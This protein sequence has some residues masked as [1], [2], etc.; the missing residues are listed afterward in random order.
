MTQ[1]MV[2]GAGAPL[3]RGPKHKQTAIEPSAVVHALHARMREVG[4]SQR[5]LSQESGVAES[6]L[7]AIFRGWS[8]P[9]LM[10]TERIATALGVRLALTFYGVTDGR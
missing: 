3:S 9:S 5:Q 6:Q 10:T 7:S 8:E 4:W 1:V 2:T